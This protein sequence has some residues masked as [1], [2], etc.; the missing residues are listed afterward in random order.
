MGRATRT[1]AKANLVLVILSLLYLPSVG[2]QALLGDR[3]D[4]MSDS[5]A[6]VTTTHQVGFE[7]LNTTDPV[8]SLVFEFCS[9]SPIIAESC[10]QPTGF[11]ISSATLAAQTGDTGFSIHTNTTANRLVL[12]RA[13]V[14]PTGVASSYTI[15][16]VINP[17]NEGTYFVRLQSFSSTDGTG[18]DIENGGIA[19]AINSPIDVSGEV[20]PYLY[21]CVGV[22]ITSFDCTS[23]NSYF[24]DFGFLSTTQ[25]RFGSSQ[26]VAGTNAVSGY[27][28]TINGT[29]LTSGSN[30]IPP[31]AVPTASSPGTS[32]FGLNLRANTSPS[33][34][35]NPV[36]GGLAAP[37]A[38]YDTPNQ[39][40]FTDTDTVASVPHSD[41]TRKFTVSYIT[42]IN[43]AQAGGVYATTISYICLANF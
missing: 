24:I 31:L 3:F 9:N 4:R 29:T 20:P 18:L 40:A 22:T 7:M 13:A 19:I 12:S 17:A 16:N 15:Q 37:D 39:F 28:V 33:I 5:R 30:T 6:G 1:I 36:G 25:P 32:Q 35:A 26:F 21:F 14:P 27:S 8:G 41:L 2:A 43:G 42:N 34:G 11:D 23:A 10:T 38:K